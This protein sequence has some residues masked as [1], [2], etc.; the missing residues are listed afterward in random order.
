VSAS[1][2]P[3]GTLNTWRLLAREPEIPDWS[4]AGLLARLSVQGYDVSQLR[5]V[6]QKPE[7]LGKL[8]FE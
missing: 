1:S 6:V 2:G 8:G 3:R 5:R 4:L 7:Q